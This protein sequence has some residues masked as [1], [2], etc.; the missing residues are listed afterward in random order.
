MGTIDSMS[1]LITDLKHKL[2]RFKEEKANLEMTR[3]KL[4][5]H[6]RTLQMEFD[7]LNT[8]ANAVRLQ[9]NDKQQM[10]DKLHRLLNE[11]KKAHESIVGNTSMLSDKLSRELNK[12][13]GFKK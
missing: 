3:T 7:H 13:D 11:S 9:V 1:T 4:Q 12:I 2:L 5:Q 10:V 6:L 8:D